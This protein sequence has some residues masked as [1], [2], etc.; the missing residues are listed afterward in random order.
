MICFIA[1]G[2]KYAN[3]DM[4]AASHEAA[5]HAGKKTER[6]EMPN[7]PCGWFVVGTNVPSWK[8]L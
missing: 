4:R 8:F 1:V 7:L 3:T 2:I 5:T 6:M